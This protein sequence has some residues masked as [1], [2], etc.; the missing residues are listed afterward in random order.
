MISRLDQATHSNEQGLP[1]SVDVPTLARSKFDDC[2]TAC[3]VFKVATSAIS[4]GLSLRQAGPRLQL[5]ASL[6]ISD[7]VQLSLN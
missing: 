3:D 6:N 5:G 4:L 2:I 1:E 7:H